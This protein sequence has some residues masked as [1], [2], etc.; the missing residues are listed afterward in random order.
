[1]ECMQRTSSTPVLLGRLREWANHTPPKKHATPALRRSPS[2]GGQSRPGT[3]DFP[4]PGRRKGLQLPALG[5]SLCMD[6]QLPARVASRKACANPAT[7][8]SKSPAA[9]E[10]HVAPALV[11]EPS[12]PVFVPLRRARTE[13]SKMPGGGRI[14]DRLRR[15]RADDRSCLG[16]KTTKPSQGLRLPSTD[17]L[18][19]LP[20]N[21]S[22]NSGLSSSSEVT[23]ANST[24]KAAPSVKSSRKPRRPRIL[25][26]ATTRFE[27]GS[28]ERS[29]STTVATSTSPLSSRGA[30]SGRA[31]YAHTGY[32]GESGS[33]AELGWTT[34]E[35]LGS[36]SYGTVYKAMDANQGFLFAVKKGTIDDRD[37]EG[38]KYKDKL[39]EEL[40]ICKHLRHPNIV[41]YLG[42]AYLDG[43]LHICL[44]YVPGGSIATLLQEFGALDAA[45]VRKASRGLTEGLD[46]LHNHKPP[47]VH[48]DIKGANALV[49]LDFTV[50]L[51]DFGCSKRGDCTKSFSCIG[52]IP[53]MA[54]E[55][56]R[57]QDGFGRKADIW[58]LGCTII[59]MATG[60]KPWGNELFS[61]NVMFALN[62][63][64]QSD[65]VP[66]VPDCMSRSGQEFVQSCV[67]RDPATRP[68]TAEMLAHDFL[69]AFTGT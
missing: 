27:D 10:G 8:S 25:T 60:E 54:P 7:D 3:S 14:G 59:E 66:S 35:R 36:G 13:E 1:M 29:F 18:A 39:E 26:V 19:E 34:G 48:R 57:Q 44:E 51:A 23:S 45:L 24:P 2:C 37:E 40:N 22:S 32:R 65:N 42:Y 49:D 16:S 9:S 50:K 64:G 47:I 55:V 17:E 4:L 58:S 63:I 5:K 43:C 62:H 12:P 68:T 21:H 38:R 53:W 31:P 61:K 67:Q 33:S 41:S 69:G 30:P 11:A 6:L 52:S 28:S 15:A 46:Y 20:R 56:I